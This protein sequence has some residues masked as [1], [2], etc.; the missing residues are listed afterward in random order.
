MKKSFSGLFVLAV[1]YYLAARFGMELCSLQPG[2]VIVVGLPSG[3]GALGCLLWGWRALPSIYL[4]SCLANAPLWM[5]GQSLW[6]IVNVLILAAVEAGQS[7][8]VM[9]MSRDKIPEGLKDVN[10]LFKLVVP[11]ALLPTLVCAIALA[12]NMALGGNIPWIQ[13]PSRALSV[14]L[15]NVLGILI[16]LP[17]YWIRKG[18]SSQ[19][20]HE[21]IRMGVYGILLCG[22]L[23]SALWD[24]F[25]LIFFTIPL[26]L[27]LSI[28]TG[29]R[30][31][32]PGQALVFITITAATAKGLGPFAFP[33][34]LHTYI[35]L[36]IFI[37]STG[38]AMM[39][40][41]ILHSQSNAMRDYLQLKVESR[42][43][44]LKTEMKQ[45]FQLERK[46]N[47]DDLTGLP[48][49]TLFFDRLNRSV[50]H[51]RRN[52]KRFALCFIGIDEFREIADNPTD[53]AVDFLLIQFA[54][55]LSRC[56]RESD[57]VA[58]IGKS[59]FTVILEDIG[60]DHDI[61]IVV[62]K[63]IDGLAKPF[64]LAGDEFEVSLSMG[65]GVYPD[66]GSG[67]EILLTNAD[68]ALYAA[69]FRKRNNWLLYGQLP[70]DQKASSI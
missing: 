65:V 4:A 69:R 53:K 66:D 25:P 15:A 33:D 45:R 9:R 49:K 32:L 1:A 39:S 43:S 52:C 47:Y 70:D 11:V 56:V 36:V 62:E 41:A 29:L 68:T 26:L 27:G 55:R 51:S 58:R 3:I 63:I 23:Y 12:A 38:I 19:A 59:E 5:D 21:K 34:T 10:D 61:E 50:I 46:A 67:A 54:R 57:T 37:G 8:W 48:N 64:Y 30:G 18:P 2:N 17:A 13:V 31:E 60:F 24:F 22:T 40:M 28:Q 20:D 42:T 44:A 7:G 35:G 14:M 16:V 6:P